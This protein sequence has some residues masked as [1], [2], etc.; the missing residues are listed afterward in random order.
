M[1]APSEAS[2]FYSI[3]LNPFLLWFTQTIAGFGSQW[4]YQLNLQVEP[5]DLKRLQELKGKRRLLLPNH[6]TFQDPIVVFLL[7]AKLNQTFYYLAAYESFKGLLGWF[8]QHIGAYSIRR[9]IADRR[10]IAYTLELMALPDC[11]LV[12]FPEGGC[13]FQ[14]DTVMPFR[15]GG[16]QIAFQ[17]MSRFAKRGETPPDFYI[18]PISIKYRYTEDMT[19]AIQASLNQ[20]ETQLG[21]PKNGSAYERL[22]AI[23]KQV[24]INL[25]QEYGLQTP[26]A[27]QEFWD[28]RIAALK[29]HV[30]QE[31]QQRLSIQP[32]PGEPIRE[33]VYRIQYAIQTKDELLED[34]NDQEAVQETIWTLEAVQKAMFRLLNFD[35]IHDSYVAENPTQE[36]FLDTL[37]R[38]EREVFNIDQPSPKGHRQARVKIDNPINLK[39]Y[40]ED[41]QQNRSRT[42]NQ[43]VLAVQQTVQRNLNQLNE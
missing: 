38:L 25:E 13:S 22:R 30:L 6:P 40:F 3:R 16:V 43:L 26:Q 32:S 36:R 23:A 9:G 5:E 8:L 21:L 12:I 10:S 29:T 20:L 37:T 33:Q 31:C 15:V 34:S 4:R 11:C 18:V 19:P 28:D 17:A 27:E 35:A 41:Y 14:N 39:D 2:G 24:L 1:P 42:I 7:S